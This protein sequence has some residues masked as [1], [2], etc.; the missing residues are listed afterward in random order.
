M[1]KLKDV[2]ECL[3]GLQNGD[4]SEEGFGERGLQGDYNILDFWKAQGRRLRITTQFTNSLDLSEG[5]FG[6]VTLIGFFNRV[7]CTESEIG[8]LDIRQTEII[9]LDLTD[10]KIGEQKR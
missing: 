10:A 7:D 9:N 4:F 3:K 6:E 5:K 2:F 8:S 1:I